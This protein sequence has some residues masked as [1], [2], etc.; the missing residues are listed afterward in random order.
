MSTGTLWPRTIGVRLDRA[1]GLA[2]YRGRPWRTPCSRCRQHSPSPGAADRT[3]PRQNWPISAVRI[4]RPSHAALLAVM[5]G[6]R[7]PNDLHWH[8]AGVVGEA[9]T[10]TMLATRAV[11]KVYAEVDDEKQGDKTGRVRASSRLADRA[12]VYPPNSSAIAYPVST[13]PRPQP[14]G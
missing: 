2:H 9:F 11:A 3:E 5:D 8:A 7:N 4:R 1:P 10:A 6:E 12:C 13:A 14:R